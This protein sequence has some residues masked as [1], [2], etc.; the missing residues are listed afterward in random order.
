VDNAISGSF[1][2]PKEVNYQTS[3]GCN[4][5]WSDRSH[6]LNTALDA[7]LNIP[8]AKRSQT[9]SGVALI[10]QEIPTTAVVSVDVWLPAGT[11]SEPEHWSGIAHFMEHMIFKGTA[12]ILPGEFDRLIETHGGISNAATSH[13]YVHFSFTTA[14][15]YFEPT[16]Q[17]LAKLLLE[18]NVPDSEFE[19]ERSVVIEEMYQA[20]D[21]PDWIAHHNLMST[22]YG[23]H[24]YS[25]PVLGYEQSLRNLTANDLRQYHDRHYRPEKMTVVVV[26][27]VGFDP[28]REAVEKAF[29]IAP[30]DMTREVHTN[31]PGLCQVPAVHI[32]QMIGIEQ[33]RLTMAWFGSDISEVEDA[34]HLDLLTMILAGGR[35][36]R[37]VKSLREQKRWVNEIDSDFTVQRSPGLFTVSAFLDTHYL[38]PVEHQ[39]QQ[40]ISNLSQSLVT[41]AEL[42]RAK[43]SLSNQFAFATE[44]PEALAGLLGYYGMLGCEIL[45]E[46]WMSGYGE[47]L[48]TATPESLQKLAQKYLPSDRYTISCLLPR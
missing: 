45:C 4:N 48:A 37:L 28:A 7:P 14:K 22:V 27:N 29:T 42:E 41:N 1:S 35:S 15:E 24:P 19:R 36:S 38:E 13:D 6:N 40:Q 20:L 26:G 43:R 17:Y 9:D 11:A 31:P 32:Q 18:A 2:N 3:Y 33:A 39:I 10:H 30:S 34:L 44:S 46:N 12:D 25:R 23:H 16:L 8:R 21:D 5:S 47:I